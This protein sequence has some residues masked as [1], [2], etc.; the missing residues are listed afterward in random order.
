MDLELI[1]R[2][3]IPAETRVV[4][5]VLDGLGGLPGPRGRSELETAATPHLDRLAQEG[6]IGQTVPAGHGITV[7]SGPG[8]TALFGLDPLQ[9]DIGRGVLEATG[10][11]F[12]IGPNDLAARGNLCT[13]D[14]DGKITDRRAGRVATEITAE[15]AQQLRTIE[16]P[17]V[18]VFVEAV[19]EHR[20][21]LVLRGE[22]LSA[23]VTE[24]DPQVEGEPPLPVEAIDDTASRTAELLNQ[25]IA[26]GRELIKDR[27]Q[28]NHLTLRGWSTRPSLPQLPELWKLRAAACTVY[29]MYRGLARLVGMESIDGGDSLQTQY[30]ALERHWDDYDFFFVHYKATDAAGEDGDFNRK[31][32]AIAEFDRQ[33]PQLL[34]LKPDVLII[35]GDHSTPATLAAHSWHPVPLLLSGATVRRDAARG[36]SEMLCA[37]GGLGTIPAAEVLPTAFAHAGRL[38]KYG[39]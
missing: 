7:G 35:A 4:L 25:F 24:T 19:R 14:G 15:I 21:V 22:G 2:L 9:F 27:D 1:R 5:C 38:A 30:E 10:I 32:E 20:F 26:A 36:F 13:V 17:G 33:L 29:P 16:L 3:S 39:A 18:E 11:D 6:A 31:V 28:A 34:A 37:T 23:A 8:H 12:E